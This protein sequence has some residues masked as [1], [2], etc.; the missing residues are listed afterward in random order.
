MTGRAVRGPLDA[1]TEPLPPMDPDRTPAVT[2]PPTRQGRAGRTI[3]L[4]AL[5]LVAAAAVA[6]PDPSATATVGEAA[7]AVPAPP[8]PPPADPVPVVRKAFHSF[9]PLQ[10]EHPGVSLVTDDAQWRRHLAQAT[11][12]PPPYAAT[13]L[14]TTRLRLMVVA[15]PPT[16]GPTATMDLAAGARAVAYGPAAQRL[17][18]RV[19][20]TDTAPAAG[21]MVA[22]VMGQP[23][24]LL[25]IRHRE[26]VRELVARTTTGRVLGLQRIP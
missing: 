1:P 7:S 8:A 25:W 3:A 10:V 24:L 5:A 2:A 14:D 16:A 6:Q 11:T 23:C 22:A 19:V 17:S 21:T 18:A 9:C 12:Q 4:S 20:F 15:G 26:P 13:D